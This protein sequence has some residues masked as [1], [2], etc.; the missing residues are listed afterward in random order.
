M[1]QRPNHRAQLGQLLAQPGIIQAPG[2]YD[3]LSAL[4]AQQAGFQAAFVSG[5]CLS[6]AHLGRQDIGLISASEACDAVFTIRDRVDLPLIV[7]IDT[8]FGN[9]LNVQRTVRDFERAGASALQMEDQQTPKRCG[10]MAGKAVI[11]TGEMVD[12]IKAALD[13][14]S[15]D[16]TLIFARTDALGVHGLDDAMERA[17][18]YVDAGADA[19][20]IEAPPALEAMQ[21]IAD[22]FASRVPLVHNLVEGGNSPEDDCPSLQKLGYKVG[23]H[24]ASLINLFTRQAG[25]M[26]AELR[27]EG[28]SRL[29]RDRMHDLD[30]VSALLGTE[31]TR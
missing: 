18:A 25:A 1:P 10:H 6:F 8:G 21:I 20:F 9:A 16:S 3:G 19:L 26:L 31:H 11:E 22:R 14:R 29:W 2:V 30:E 12:K 17:Q 28:S 5:A 7:D 23:L 4:L 15:D 27:R 24:P 13:A